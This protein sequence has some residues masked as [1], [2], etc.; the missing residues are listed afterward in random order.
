[1]VVCG[2]HRYQAVAKHL[3]QSHID[4]FVRLDL[5]NAQAE[6]LAVADNLWHSPLTK[7]QRGNS[8]MTWFHFRSAWLDR[9]YSQV[10]APA[11]GAP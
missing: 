7:S 1:M 5:D 3:K 8:Y 6:Q 11:W 2:R 9:S 10:N 4:A